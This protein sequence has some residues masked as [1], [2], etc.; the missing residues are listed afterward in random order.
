MIQYKIIHRRYPD[1]KW[2]YKA[3]STKI[4]D[5]RSYRSNEIYYCTVIDKGKKRSGVEVYSGENYILDSTDKSYSRSYSMK[6]IPD[7]YKLTV[8]ELKRIHESTLW[9]NAPY[10]NMN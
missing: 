5:P 6:Q 8:K 1:S 2:D 10:V 4:F 3:I 7:K 9:S